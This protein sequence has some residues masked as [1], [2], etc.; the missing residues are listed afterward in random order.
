MSGTVRHPVLLYDGSCGMC[1]R[2]VQFVLRHDRKGTLRFASL[3]G[4]WARQVTESR[5]SLRGVDS[6]VW[7]EA[8]GEALVRS[9]AALRVMTGLGGVWRLAT[10][11]WIV[12]RP[13]RDAVYDFVA[14]HRHRSAAPAEQCFIPP[15]AAR[16]RFLD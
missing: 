6:V 9:A 14:R 4:A 1:S 5:P 2:V 3:Q 10:V 13:V 15:P 11:L 12:P 8:D 7:V 16:E